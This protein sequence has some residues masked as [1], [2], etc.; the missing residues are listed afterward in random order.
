M[1]ANPSLGT[2]AW[3]SICRSSTRATDRDRFELKT[4]RFSV[5]QLPDEIRAERRD[6]LRLNGDDSLYGGTVTTRRRGT[7]GTRCSARRSDTYVVD[8]VLDR[9]RARWA[10]NRPRQV[11]TSRSPSGANLENLTLLAALLNGT[12]T[13][14]ANIITGTPP[15]TRSTGWPRHHAR[16]AGNDTF[17][18]DNPLDVVGEAGGS[19]SDVV[20]SSVTFSLGASAHVIGSVERLC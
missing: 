16:L 8:N 9:S 4:T 18:V 15:P 5:I 10:G 11:G 19:G 3:A 2:P 14:L 17:V 6:C 7:A 12:A 20:V 1:S 13:P